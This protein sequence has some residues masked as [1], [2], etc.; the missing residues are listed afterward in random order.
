MPTT[1]LQAD[2]PD[3]VGEHTT[4]NMGARPM[5]GAHALQKFS[6][7]GQFPI[8]GYP[9]MLCLPHILQLYVGV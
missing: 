7:M 4:Q 1:P 3:C 8:M 2:S 9:G 6:H 5:L